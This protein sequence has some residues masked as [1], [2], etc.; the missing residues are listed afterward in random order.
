MHNSS[1]A[2]LLAL[3]ISLFSLTSA[4]ATTRAEAFYEQ[5][6]EA[7]NQLQRSIN[8]QSGDTEELDRHLDDFGTNI[9]L[10]AQLGHPAAR[11]FQAQERL[12]RRSQDP[13]VALEDRRQG[14]ASLDALART[15]FVAAAVLNAQA[16]DTAYKRFEFNSPEHL[17][18]IDAVERSLL[19]EDPAMA[20]YPLPMRASQCFA[21]DPAQVN[22]LSHEQF[23]AE[24]EYILGNSQAP[25]SR[26]AI[27][28]NL[29][30]LE[31]AFEHGCTAS[32]DMRPV[33]RQQL[34]KHP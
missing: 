8:E 16:C 1:L 7:L 24:A 28:R 25:E 31:A 2:W 32:L 26:E 27:E 13:L 9:D 19:Q 21:V 34:A 20:Y 10:A 4:A 11:L 23:R 6:M 33:L 17:A 5:G 30:W 22:T 29:E 18:V 12:K 14:C 3:G 15:G